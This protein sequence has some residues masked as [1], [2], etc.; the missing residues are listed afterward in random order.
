VDLELYLQGVDLELCLLGVDLDQY[1]LEV[2]QDL[3][4]YC[5][6]LGVGQDQ[7]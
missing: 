5:H 7:V 6:L 3:Q 2:D 4:H 1:L